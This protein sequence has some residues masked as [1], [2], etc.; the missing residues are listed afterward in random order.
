MILGKTAALRMHGEHILKKIWNYLG[1]KLLGFFK[2]NLG[3]FMETMFTRHLES[4]QM[5]RR[6]KYVENGLFYDETV[7]PKVL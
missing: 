1:F 2:Q 7:T 5:M 3:D 4:N 6:H